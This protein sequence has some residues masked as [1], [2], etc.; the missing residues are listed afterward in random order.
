MTPE[1]RA[2]LLTD[3]IFEVPMSPQKLYGQVLVALREAVK[4]ERERAAL[5]AMGYGRRSGPVIARAITNGVSTD[6][7]ERQYSN[8]N[9][10][11]RIQ[12]ANQS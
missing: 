1:H 3:L 9:V 10:F 12:E 8:Y 7:V 4:D 6:E 11:E 5:I 2:R